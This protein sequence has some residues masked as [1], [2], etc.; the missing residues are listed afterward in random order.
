MLYYTI[1]YYTILYYTILYYT[2]L[3]NVCYILLYYC[4]TVLHYTI[5]LLA[6][7][8]C[9][10]MAR[11]DAA[12]SLQRCTCS[13]AHPV[14]VSSNTDV[15]RVWLRTNGVNTDDGLI[16]LCHQ[17]FTCADLHVDRCSDPLPW[18]LRSSP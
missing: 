13:G 2:I 10:G 6:M 14:A 5:I 11:S 16:A 15:A 1:L 9:K 4:Y 8:C 3:C 17:L 7:A 12:R 18:D